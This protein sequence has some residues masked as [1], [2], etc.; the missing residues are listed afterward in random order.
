ML[1]SDNKLEISRKT[2]ERWLKKH[3]LLKIIKLPDNTFT[4]KASV[5]VSIFIFKAHEPQKEKEIFACWI[6]EDGL[7]TVKNK[8]RQDIKGKWKNELEDYW[9]NIIYKQSGN[10]TCQWLKP[11]E[12]LSYKMPETPFEISENDFKKVVLDYMLFERGIDK[13]EFE[14]TILEKV[15]YESDIIVED[16]TIKITLKDEEDEK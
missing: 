2:V 16:K 4:G 12:N 15:L 11:S 14:K 10:E 13:K 1:I 8:G 6:K 3:S 5:N 7:E 9:Y